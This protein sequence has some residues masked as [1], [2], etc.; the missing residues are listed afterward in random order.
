VASPSASPPRAKGVDIPT[1]RSAYNRP[2]PD[3]HLRASGR[4]SRQ[5]TP[6][7]LRMATRADSDVIAARPY[8]SDHAPQLQR[9]DR[10]RRRQPTGCL[11]LHLAVLPDHVQSVERPDMPRG[12]MSALTGRRSSS[13]RG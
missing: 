6:Q 3:E 9:G 7:L 10:A 12:V 8:S 4:P 13:I 1:A 11:V 5:R 2:R